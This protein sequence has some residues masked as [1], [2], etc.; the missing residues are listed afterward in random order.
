MARALAVDLVLISLV[1][2]F[3]VRV[4]DRLT[5]P[6]QTRSLRRPAVLLLWVLW[7]GLLAARATAGLIISQVIWWQQVTTG[8][9]FLLVAALLV[10]LWLAAPGACRGAV[11]LARGA[12]MLLGLCIF[13][14]VPVLVAAGFAHQPW[15]QAQFVKPLPVAA[16]PHRRIVWL[17]FDEMSYDQ[18]FVHRWPG[19]E[20]PNL[21][22][23]RAESVTFSDVEPDGFYTEDV[24]PSI[25][26]GNP[27]NQVLGTPSGWML[28]RTTRRAPWQ[29]FDGRKT[30]FADAQREG[31][32][33]GAIG[34]YNPYCRILKDQLDFCWMGMPPLPDHFSRSKTTLEN[35]AA[36][37]AANWK[38]LFEPKDRPQPVPAGPSPVTGLP[39][40]RAGDDL[41]NDSQIDLCF[42]HLPVPHPPG[43][44]DRRTGKLRSG[45]SYIDNLALSDRIL[46]HMLA[47]IA[48]S[49]AAGRT[50][51]ILS[52]DHSWRTWLWG[53]SYGWT[54]E[55]ELAS[56]HR[57]FD[58]RPMLMVWFPG[59]T[60]PATIARPV[61]LL[62]MH[63]LVE[64]IMIG[65]IESPQQLE[66]WAAKQ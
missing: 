11:R 50:T 49:P 48:A 55:D 28:Y 9:V 21:D 20:L 36:P 26:L 32:T 35:I 59:E 17:L 15:D 65:E 66:A 37:L 46:G 13:W 34:D 10:I 1:G 45:G 53:H 16:A 39:E 12:I 61:P 60:V 62:S 27:I 23:L 18:V 22:K 54:R 5:S 4:L 51:V 42:V 64:R 47:E 56:G 2:M 40:V 38:R 8:R 44:Y 7:L 63:Q 25:F 6:G 30:L 52:S 58:P 3:V 41:I 31:W 19:L 33:T 24:I 14:M 29:S 43:K 57:H